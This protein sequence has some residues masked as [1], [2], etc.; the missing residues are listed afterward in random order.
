VYQARR[1]ILLQGLDHL[2]LEYQKPR[3]SFY[4]WAKTPAGLR[5]EEF[6]A[7][8]LSE[9]GIMAAPGTGYGP[10]GEGYFR[11]ALIVSE[12]RMREAVKRLQRFAAIRPAAEA[13]PA[14]R[15]EP[16]PAG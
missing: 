5:S 8:L 14:S 3:G 2:K 6:V 13:P 15:V 4:V 10:E 16:A 12:E 7:R 11:M 1:D 9:T